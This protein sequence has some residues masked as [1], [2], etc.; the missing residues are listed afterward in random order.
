MPAP[1][2]SG[3]LYDQFYVYDISFGAITTGATISGTVNIDSLSNFLWRA[4]TFWTNPDGVTLNT[5]LTNAFLRPFTI[6]LTDAG[7]GRQFFN[8][9]VPVD[10]IAGSGNFPFIL[11]EPYLWAGNS[12]VQATITNLDTH[13]WDNLHLSLIGKKTFG[14]YPV[15][16]G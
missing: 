13:T 9:A 4:T 7:T 5:P 15:G 1:G 2:I 6:S 10:N 11:P 14:S 8:G 12:V 3:G 16:N